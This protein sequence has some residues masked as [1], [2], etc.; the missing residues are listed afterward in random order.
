MSQGAEQLAL[1]IHSVA[2]SSN[3]TDRK[4][5]AWIELVSETVEKMNIVQQSVKETAK[6]VNTLS[7]KLKEI[8]EE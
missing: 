2:E 3:V 8:A 6:T 1:S 7:G 4:A 5:V